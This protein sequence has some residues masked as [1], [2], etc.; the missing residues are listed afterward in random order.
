MALQSG[1]ISAAQFL[2]L[3]AHIGGLDNE[4]GFTTARDA[5]SDAMAST[6]YRTGQ[7][8]DVHRL[9]DVPIVDVRESVDDDDPEALS[10][11]HQPYNTL[12]MRARLDAANSTHANQ[13]SWF[14]P[15]ANVDVRAVLTVDRWLTAVAKDSRPGSKAAKIIRSKPTDIRDT[16]WVSGQPVTDA[17]TCAQKFP[18][19]RYGGTARIAAGGPLASDMRKCHL[20]PLNRHDYRVT[21]TPVEWASLR[22]IFPRGVC[23]WGRPS[24]GYQRA[25]PWM[26]FDRV[27]GRPL[28][29]APVSV[30][31]G[32]RTVRGKDVVSSSSSPVAAPTRVPASLGTTGGVTKPTA[33]SQLGV[34]GWEVPPLVIGALLVAVIGR[35]ATARA[36]V[37]HRPHD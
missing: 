26:T 21:F 15:P 10:D 24:V 35:R 6:F 12:A 4:G 9:A 30:P 28:G 25:L 13:V 11:M 3:N 20:K 2:D 34:T 32:P 5:M 16:C 19:P 23:D 31:F 27:G 1:S 29:V 37:G 14:P 17:K 33:W 36:G 8:T 7:V 22:A 18:G